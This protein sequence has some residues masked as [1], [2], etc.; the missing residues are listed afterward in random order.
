[1]KNPV[2]T[3]ETCRLCDSRALELAVHFV[4]TPIGDAF[5]PA[6]DLDKTQPTFPL[7][8]LVCKD[9]GNAQ[10]LNVVDPDLI[11]SEYTYVSSVSLG[12]VEHFRRYADAVINRAQ[13]RSGGLVVEIGSNEGAMLRPFQD[14][15]FQTLG[16]DPARAIALRAT[17]SG[18]ETLPT[19]FTAELAK[20][21]R[22]EKG[23]ASIMIAN[24]V[25]ANIDDVAD[26]AEGLRLLLADDGVFVFETSYWLPVIEH[27]LIDTV[28]HEHLTYFAV[29]PLVRFFDRFGMEFYDVEL[30]PTKGGSIRG[31]VQLKGG[32]RPVTS[33][34]QT[35][36]DLEKQAG[37]D[38]LDTYK[39][40][41]TDLQVLKQDLHTRLNEY[42]QAGKK[43]AAYGAAVGLTTMIYHFDLGGF[44]DFIVDDNT[45]KHHLFSPGLH[46]PTLPSD[47]LYEKK[48]DIVIGLAFRYMDPI[49]KKHAAFLD[50]G[51]HFIVPLPKL[52]V[53]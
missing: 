3:R 27:K 50:A 26:L 7:D 28:F 17:E 12:L 14:R 24:N 21:I 10:L 13:P 47:A 39:R 41:E 52:E 9:C 6:K 31:Y 2:Y 11:Y 46:L 4:P 18:I 40:Y 22:A 34:I 42:K 43:I 44:I 23:S 48:P 38:T 53:I 30:V 33:A 51:G 16:V 5:V 45:E 20:T 49:L 15:G 19:Y 32:R 35:Q 37:L 8:V 1:M 36:I 25:F 29:T